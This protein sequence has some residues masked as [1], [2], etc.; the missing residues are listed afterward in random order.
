MKR[1]VRIGG[2]SLWLDVTPDGDTVRFSIA[3]DSSGSASIIEAEPGIYSV[4]LDGKSY[5][6]HLS[7]GREQW[8]ASLC[9]RE[10]A[11]DVVDPRA[12]S[13][14]SNAL[15]GHGQQVLSAPMPGKIVKRL[16]KEGD[17][18]EAGQGIIV[19][20]A[21]KMQNEMRAVHAGRVVSLPVSEGAT[22]T[23]GDTLAIIE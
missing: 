11:L 23:A 20:E 4:L 19:V 21:M 14:R 7:R 9:G 15:G 22:V 6:V 16:V 5:R 12:R 13:S 8:L 1:E 17:H 18:V 3:G 10:Y 2:K